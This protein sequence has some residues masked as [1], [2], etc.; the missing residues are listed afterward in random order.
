MKIKLLLVD[1]SIRKRLPIFIMKAFIFFLCTTVFG[2]SSTDSFSQEKVMIDQDQ[3]VT[4]D[5]VF[6]IIKK[7]TNYRFIYPKKAFENASKIQLKKGEI[8]VAYLLEQSLSDKNLIFELTENN[9]IVIKRAKKIEE[10][11]I[12]QDITIKGMVTDAS[13][14]AL[15]GATIQV[16]GTTKG[17]STD[18]D[19]KYQITLPKGSIISVSYVGYVTKEILV[20]NQTI[21]NIELKEDTEDLD[22]IVIVG[23]GTQ[24]KANLTGSVGSVTGEVLENRPIASVGQGLQG[25]IP[26][27]NVNIRNGDPAQGIDFNVRGFESINGGNPLIL[28]DG[29]PGNLNTLNPNDI[30]SVTVLK[31]A[32]AAAV[33]GARAAFGV[34]LVETKKGKSGKMKATFSAEYAIAKPIIF[35]DP[36]N[37]PYEYA[38]ARNKAELRTNGVALYDDERLA[39]LKAYSDNPTEANAWY[40]DGTDL[41]YNGFNDYQNK[42]LAD[43]SPQEQYNM[44]ISGAN[45]K[46]S[47]Y[48]SF[49]HLSKDGYLKND[50]KNI[51]FKRYNALIKGD[52]KIKD[53]LSLDSRALVSIEKDDRPHPYSN[54]AY[55][56]T[57]ARV[58]PITPLTFPDLPYYIMPGDRADFEQYIG[59]HY[60][61]LNFLPYIEQGGRNVSKRTNLTL[62]QGITLNPIK[63]LNVRGE[64]SANLN[65]SNAENVRSKVNVIDSEF[66]KNLDLNSIRIGN[67]FSETDYIEN[68]SDNDQYFVFNTYADYTIDNGD[69]HYFKGMVGFNQEWGLFQYIA[70][71]ANSL[72]TPGVTDLNAT[73]GTQQTFG[74]KEDVSLRGA[75]YRINYIYK[76]KYLFEFNGRYDGTSRFPKDDRFGFFPSSSVGWRITKENFMSGTSSWLS[77]LK[78]RWSYGTLGNQLLSDY[79][80]AISTMGVGTSRYRFAPGLTPEPYVT[81]ANLVSPTL[82]WE[83]VTTRNF[84]VDIAL[85]KNRFNFSLD[86]YTRETA[87][88]LS[89]GDPLPGIAGTDSPA[90]NAA[91]LETKGWEISA[92]WKD[93]VGKDFNYDVTLAFADS[94][95]KIT[96]FDNPTG[97]LD[98]RYVGQTI[99]EIWGFVTEGIFQSDQEVADAPDQS[100]LG[101]NW[102]AGDIRYADLN[103]DGVI[104]RG[105]NTLDDPGDQKI[106][107][108]SRPRGNFG[109]TSNIRYKAFSLNV[110]FQGVLAYDYL[111]SAA[112]H[113]LFYP[114]NS[115]AVERYYLTD[116][117]SEDNRD[118]YFSAPY[119]SAAGSKKNILPQSRYVQDGAY[120]RLKNLTLNYNLP[121]KLLSAIGM[122]QASIYASGMNL[123]E[124]TKMRKPLDPEVRPT[125]NQEYYKQR[126]YSLGLKVSF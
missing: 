107:G 69:D 114:F 35:F 68:R 113:Q 96:K 19:G 124:F 62:T 95:S 76:D 1:S 17:T 81:P 98:T 101:T 42:L 100:Q 64:F 125:L 5:E 15:P 122:S 38:L 27:L 94:E 105:N 47:Y 4:I 10:D 58:S 44:S 22:E 23:Y 56:N 85:F 73:T 32:A 43:Y 6:K 8:N 7:Q 88:M 97:S 118:A 126:I 84:G 2:L 121:D 18:F 102:Q 31:D 120:I 50:A 13:G 33:Y 112:S 117:W 34:V 89:A 54:D 25:V 29:V 59:L 78:L 48:A 70:A 104:T 63:R 14:V 55:L 82:T 123:F 36:V 60:Q 39:R 74:G 72:I 99:G 41:E 51:K 28:I 71:R 16:V 66:E 103:G 116:T 20:D 52:A 26:N 83:S 110:F 3:L 53:W 77:D 40:V 30:A 61:T 12:L 108:V 119:N 111:P 109:I 92:T 86:L 11:E 24:K 87:D 91:D 106:I 93:N 49:G 65:Y 45:D 21:I 37:D 115:G 46:S 80:P 57:L 75:F 79:Y 9:T 67:G 90:I